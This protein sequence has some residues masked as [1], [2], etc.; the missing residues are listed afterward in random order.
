MHAVFVEVVEEVSLLRLVDT[1][2]HILG[3]QQGSDDAHKLHRR[4]HVCN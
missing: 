2:Q 3:V 4:A 1:G